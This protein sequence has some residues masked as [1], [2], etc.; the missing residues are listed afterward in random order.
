MASDSTLGNVSIIYLKATDSYGETLET[1]ISKGFKVNPETTYSTADTAIRALNALT[2]NTYD[3]SICV[4]NILASEQTRED[5]V[6]NVETLYM[7]MVTPTGDPIETNI[8]KG[9]IIDP[10]A[11]YQKIIATLYGF[12]DPMRKSLI[13]L[14]TNTYT[15]SLLVTNVS[16]NEEMAE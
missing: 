9:F 2:K 4:T 16:V 5:A 6:G 10:E 12:G 7:E 14:T 1:N 8:S 15:D 3:D 11:T 13:K